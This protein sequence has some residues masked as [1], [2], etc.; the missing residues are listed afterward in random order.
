MIVEDDAV[1]RRVLVG[2]LQKQDVP[3]LAVATC[4]QAIS[5]QK[6]EPADLVICDM[7]LP[8]GNGLSLLKEFKAMNTGL[9]IIIMTGFGTIESAVQAMKCGA[10]NYLLKPFS[11]DQLDLAI[12]Q[13]S[14]QKELSRQNKYLRSQIAE[15]ESGDLM[16]TSTE[17]ER[18][19]KLISQIADTDA[20]VLIE[21]ESGTGKEVIARSIFEKS[22]RHDKP[23]IKVNCAAVPEN[24]LESEFF[25][26]EKGSFTGA[27]S[28]REGRFEL[29]NGGTLL[30]DE[31]TEISLPLQAKLLRVLQE[32]EFE[33][34]GSN[35]TIKVDVRILATT[36]C[37][38]A[39]AVAEGRFRKDLFYRLNVVPIRVPRLAE[40][41]GD[42]AFLLTSFLETFS[43]R[44]N[45]PTPVI[46]RQ[47][48]D[49]LSGY[50]WPG[51]VRE[52]RNYAER[53]V[54]LANTD[55][56]PE[57]DQLAGGHAITASVDPISVDSQHFPTLA[58]VEKRLIKLAMERTKGSRK[59]A[60]E[61][62]GIN[63][64]TLRNKLKEY[65]HEDA[66]DG[67]EDG[68]SEMDRA[69]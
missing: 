29:A 60:A 64:R 49:K 36:N 44:H 1:F 10:S 58:E 20:T 22:L 28:R 37:N 41:K 65:G 15:N 11:V 43:K 32:R 7:Q 9:D 63:V 69:A 54:I 21:G 6:R 62:I 25:G 50:S 59:D 14:H 31:I 40:R 55:L 68:D 8:D 57:V 33:R 16:F 27:T 24:L 18:V 5:E 47:K 35:R 13:I 67:G 3:V 66:G 26:H 17:M 4:C 53:V 51:N 39:T 45:K 61:L 56:A 48:M 38:L 42:V 12:S 34:V 23:Y 19:H 2:I 46:T 30:L 52:L